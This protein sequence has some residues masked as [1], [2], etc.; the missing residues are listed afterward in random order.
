MSSKCAPEAMLTELEELCNRV[1]THKPWRKFI[2]LVFKDEDIR[3]RLLSAPAAKAV[4]HAYVGGLLEHTLSVTQFC[5]HI[6]DHYPEIDRQILTVAGVVHDLGK[7]WELSV[8]LPMLY[9]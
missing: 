8:A 1:L 4:H 9:G 7:V 6:A 3:P 5:Q 2:Q